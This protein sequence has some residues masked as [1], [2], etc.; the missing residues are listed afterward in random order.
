MGL[1]YTPE[2]EREGEIHNERV[3]FADWLV[4]G[5][6]GYSFSVLSPRRQ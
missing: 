1:R 3:C 2:R 4:C 6:V 5:L